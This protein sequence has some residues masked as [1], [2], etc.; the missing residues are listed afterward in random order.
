MYDNKYIENL[1]LL[2]YNSNCPWVTLSIH[3]SVG[4][5]PIIYFSLNCN[6][7]CPPVKEILAL[8]DYVLHSDLTLYFQRECIAVAGN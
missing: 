6:T 8:V 5:I 7:T 2:F 3:V 4:L 1:K